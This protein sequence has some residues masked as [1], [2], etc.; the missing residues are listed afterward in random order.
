MPPP[1]VLGKDLFGGTRK[2]VSNPGSFTFFMTP[3]PWMSSSK[4]HY[5]VFAVLLLA[6][7][8]HAVVSMERKHARCM[9]VKRTGGSKSHPINHPNEGL[10]PRTD[11]NSVPKEPAPWGLLNAPPPQKQD[12]GSP[13]ADKDDDQSAFQ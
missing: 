5:I 7:S 6:C 2:W 10:V 4:V 11:S 8:L 3:G 13:R 12:D 1:D 9:Q